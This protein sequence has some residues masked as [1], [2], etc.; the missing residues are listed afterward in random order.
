[1]STVAADGLVRTTRRP[2]ILLVVLG[3]APVAQVAQVA[4]RRSQVAGCAGCAALGPGL[5]LAAARRPR[6]RFFCAASNFARLH[7]STVGGQVHTRSTP[8]PHQV[9]MARRH[10][11]TESTTHAARPAT[12]ARQKIP[13]PQSASPPP[14]SQTGPLAARRHPRLELVC[15]LFLTGSMRPVRDLPNLGPRG[16]SRLKTMPR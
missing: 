16:P 4:G 12:T 13:R 15:V 2:T 9:H 5:V 8:G 10:P 14:P 11:R 6:P 1:M 3:V 7:T